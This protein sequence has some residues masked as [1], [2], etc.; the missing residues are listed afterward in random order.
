M[1]KLVEIEQ[2]ICDI[3]G[4]REAYYKCNGCGID[5]CYEC[6]EVHA[7]KYSHSLYCSGSGDGLYC[8]DCNEKLSKSDDKLYKAYVKIQMLKNE[9]KGWS[10]DFN[11]RSKLAEAKLQTLLYEENK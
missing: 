10:E 11:Q 3:C 8:N 9:A 2:T 1:K 6:I 4:K 7:V 5:I